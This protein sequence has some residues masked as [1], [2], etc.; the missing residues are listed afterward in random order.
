MRTTYSGMTITY[1]VLKLRNLKFWTI[2]IFTKFKLVCKTLILIFCENLDTYS[3]NI[4]ADSDN[5]LKLLKSKQNFVLKVYIVITSKVFA[6]FR[7]ESPIS[8]DFQNEIPALLPPKSAKSEWK[9]M[10]TFE[11][12]KVFAGSRGKSLQ[13][14]EVIFKQT[15]EVITIQTFI[16]K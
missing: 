12:A 16:P 11:G 15:L 9:P 6:D 2:L 10:L 8:I 5:H 7:F 13:T 1:E 14:L 4:F 3:G